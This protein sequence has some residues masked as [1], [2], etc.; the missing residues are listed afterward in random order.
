MGT[1]RHR[2]SVLMFCG[3]H[4]RLVHVGYLAH[5]NPYVGPPPPS[6]PPWALPLLHAARGRHTTVDAHAAGERDGL[7]HTYSA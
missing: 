5:L 2:L 4:R 1:L 3:M 7:R 6:T